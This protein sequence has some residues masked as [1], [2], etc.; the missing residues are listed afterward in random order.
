VVAGPS[1]EESISD[2]T[3]SLFSL[4]G[5]VEGG[6]GW[7]GV[8]PGVASLAGS[9]ER[10]HAAPLEFQEVASGLLLLA[11]GAGSHGR[12]ISRSVLSTVE[13]GDSSVDLMGLDIE[14]GPV[15]TDVED[16]VSLLPIR[17][18]VE[19]LHVGDGSETSAL[20]PDHAFTK[21]AGTGVVDTHAVTVAGRTGELHGD[22]VVLR[23][24]LSELLAVNK[25]EA[26]LDDGFLRGVKVYIVTRE[27]EEIVKGAGASPE[28]HFDFTNLTESLSS[29]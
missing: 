19:V 18:F 4:H 10:G 9:T 26:V 24:V 8:S 5:L 11:T 13:D 1:A 6:L 28:S 27:R 15:F 12:S 7:R 21:S 20:H 23:G 2:D 22:E 17:I 25:D 3:E 14:A 29:P 16:D